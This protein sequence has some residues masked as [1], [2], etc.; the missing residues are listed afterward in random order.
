[1]LVA[2]ERN[3][4]L[5]ETTLQS[6]L[7]LPPIDLN[8]HRELPTF[9]ATLDYQNTE[10]FPITSEIHDIVTFIMLFSLFSIL[11][12]SCA[13]SALISYVLYEIMFKGWI[14]RT[15]RKNIERYTKVS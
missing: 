10:L 13:I 5:N 8:E 6:C 15:A 1:M 9:V 4:V 12:S 11:T 14:A 7:G 3:Q 2:Q